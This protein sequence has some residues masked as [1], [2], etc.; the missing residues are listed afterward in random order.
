M[1]SSVD[2]GQSMS[3]EDSVAMTISHKR[4]TDSAKPLKL[5]AIKGI[6]LTAADQMLATLS[7][8]VLEN[9]QYDKGTVN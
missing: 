2:E 1:L 8:I 3:E 7:E 6:L 4:F 9:A 5:N